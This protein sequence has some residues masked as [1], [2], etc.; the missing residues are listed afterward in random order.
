MTPNSSHGNALPVQSIN[1]YGNTAFD[2]SEPTIDV[3]ENPLPTAQEMARLTMTMP[4]EYDFGESAATDSYEYGKKWSDSTGAEKTIQ[5]SSSDENPSSE[6]AGAGKDQVDDIVA[7]ALAY[8][9]KSNADEGVRSSS[10]LGGPSR[11]NTVHNESIH[12]F[13]SRSQAQSQGTSNQDVDEMVARVLNQAGEQ[14]AQSQRALPRR[15]DSS[16]YSEYS[17]QTGTDSQL[18]GQFNC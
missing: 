1:A 14:A 8:A 17:Q 13:Y 6:E 4:M 7:A 2:V 12:S 11:S 3:P 16:M 9:E 15:M 5:R 10:S 18:S